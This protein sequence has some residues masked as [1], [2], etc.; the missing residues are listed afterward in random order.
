MSACPHCAARLETPVFCAACGLP[1]PVAEGVGPFEILG[2][3]PNHAVDAGLLKRRMLRASRDVHP[4]FFA[5]A[6]SDVRELAGRNSALLNAAFQTLSDDVE[7]AN[8]LVAYL[9]G[10]DEQHERTMPAEFL[11]EVLEWNE[12]LEEARAIT[13]GFDPRLAGLKSELSERRGRALTSIAQLLTP[14]PERGAP[15]LT[16]VRRHLNAVRYVDRALSEIEA[17]RLARAATR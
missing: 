1:L 6:P 17:L 4:D 12:R 7:R 10:P 14:L 5:T 9:G 11:A 2:L 15:S 8:W 16:I 13:S 3:A